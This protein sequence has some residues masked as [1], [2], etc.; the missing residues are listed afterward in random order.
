VWVRS[1]EEGRRLAAPWWDAIA[2]SNA[3]GQ[4]AGALGWI[5]T[6]WRWVAVPLGIAT[7]IRVLVFLFGYVAAQMVLRKPQLPLAVWNWW[8]SSHYVR[9]ARGGY[10]YSPTQRWEPNFFP[11][12]PMLIHLVEPLARPFG[13]KES[14]LLAGV[15]ISWVTFGIACVVLYHLAGERFGYGA[16]T[17]AVLLLSIFPFSFYFGGAFTESIYLL[18]A[19]LAF[20]AVERGHWWLAG[21]ACLLAGAVRPPGLLVGA[22]V[23]L[24]YALDWWRTRHPWRL[25]VL[26]LGLTPLG[27]LAYFTYLWVRFG[28]VLAYFHASAVGWQ[29]GHLQMA[30]LRV[31]W[32]LLLHLP[33][34]LASGQYDLIQ[35]SI[36]VII[37]LA[38]LAAS[39]PVTRLLGI[40]LGVFTAA[41]VLLPVATYTGVNSMGRYAS[42]AFPIFILLAVW[43]ERWPVARDLVLAGFAIFLGLFTA[44]FVAGYPLA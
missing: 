24:A 1:V 23:V 33:R 14:Y 37:L 38:V 5:G 11:L 43:L 42:V 25:D 7:S 16:G 36:Y 21:G 39:I 27:T 28:D 15:A 40:P 6:A 32:D 41:S 35:G 12:Y 17:T 13:G 4:R 10:L 9:I 29:G 20:Y 44:L 8:D 31:S 30:G 3:I 22:C 18:L 2:E 19:V 34:N 26:A